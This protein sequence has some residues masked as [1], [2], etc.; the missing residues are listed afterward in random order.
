MTATFWVY[1]LILIAISSFILYKIRKVETKFFKFL[2]YSVIGLLSIYYIAH[3]YNRPYIVDSSII[4]SAYRN[5]DTMYISSVELISKNKDEKYYKQSVSTESRTMINKLCKNLR[6]SQKFRTDQSQE[7]YKIYRCKINFKDGSYLE[8]P[9]KVSAVFG[10]F[11]EIYAPGGIIDEHL[12]DY[13]NDSLKSF[14]KLMY[15]PEEIDFEYK[16]GKFHLFD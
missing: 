8:F 13:R 4:T 14:I 10:F 9:I 6:Y 1:T 7:I 2:G 15:Y 11:Y 5:F 3:L 12:G 16:K